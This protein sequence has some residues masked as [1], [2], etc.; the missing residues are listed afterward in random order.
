MQLFLVVQVFDHIILV[1]A[2][3]FWK[4][5]SSIFC[6]VCKIFYQM[7]YPWIQILDHIDNAYNACQNEILHLVLHV[8]L[9]KFEA[10]LAMFSLKP[11]SNSFIVVARPV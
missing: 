6:V 3:V 10:Y 9:S 8:D 5:N 4:R 1:T 7:E 2:S 11:A